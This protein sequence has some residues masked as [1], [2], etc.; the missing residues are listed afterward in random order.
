LRSRE[1]RTQIRREI[2]G[3]MVCPEEAGPLAFSPDRT[4]LLTG[5]QRGSLIVWDVR[6]GQVPSGQK[7]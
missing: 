2:V 1:A 6:R 7:K 4:N 5:L 3:Q